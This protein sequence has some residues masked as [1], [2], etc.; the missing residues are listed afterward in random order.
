VLVEETVSRLQRA[1]IHAVG[2]T[3]SDR[4]HHVVRRIVDEASRRGCDTIVLGSLRLRGLES[5]LGH[6]TR[7][8]VLKLSSLPVIVRPPA[9]ATGE[10]GLARR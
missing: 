7:E 6:G 10:R 9:R 3:C 2:D 4:E 8:R 1:G 5:V